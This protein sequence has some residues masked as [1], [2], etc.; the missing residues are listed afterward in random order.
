MLL[1]WNRDLEEQCD[2]WKEATVEEAQLDH[3]RCCFKMVARRNV[4]S[5]IDPEHQRPRYVETYCM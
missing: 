2:D 5:R 1:W 3:G 4:T